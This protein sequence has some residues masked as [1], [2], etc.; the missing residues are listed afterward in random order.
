MINRKHLS[1]VMIILLISGSVMAL[2]YGMDFNITLESKSIGQK[3]RISFSDM[4]TRAG[5]GWFNMTVDNLGDQGEYC[6]LDVDSQNR[7][8]IAYYDHTNTN[9]KYTYFDGEQWVR[10]VVEN[11]AGL[12]CSIDLDMMDRPH[13][14]YYDPTGATTGN[15]K[16]AYHDGVQ[17]VTEVADPGWDV[18]EY[19]SIKI[20]E[21]GKPHIS[22]HDGDNLTL[23]YVYY[24]GAAWV[25]TTID[26]DAAVGFDT[27]LELN[28]SGYPAIAYFDNDNGD[29][30]YAY[31]D[32]A[33]WHKEAV[34]SDDEVGWGASLELNSTE[35]P[36]ISYFDETNG[37]IKYAFYNMTQWEMETVKI[38]GEAGRTTSLSLD[39]LDMPHITYQNG[40]SGD[41]EY[42]FNA[43]GGEWQFTIVDSGESEGKYNSL[44]LGSDHLPQI[45]YYKQ[46]GLN[47]LMYAAVDNTQP[48]INNDQSDDT[49]T[50]GD[51]FWFRLNAS[52]NFLLD[53]LMVNWTHGEN[54]GNETL[55]FFND[56]W[57]R[58][59]SAKH[60]LSPL[61]Y[62]FYITDL[63]G[64]L[65][66]SNQVSIPVT[67][68]DE[69]TVGQDYTP[70]IFFA[71]DN[72]TFKI[73]CRDNIQLN[74]VYVRYV[75]GG[76]Q[77]NESMAIDS[78][79]WTHSY[80]V[81]NILGDI[82]YSFYIS[83][84]SGNH[85]TTSIDHVVQSD[86]DA[87]I[88]VEEA[89]V[90]EPQT[91]QEFQLIVKIT[92]DSNI[93]SVKANYTFF[94]NNHTSADMVFLADDLWGVL[95]DVP[96][97]TTQ[98]L[99]HI[100]AQDALG[101]ILDTSIS[102]GNFQI[103]VLDI[104]RPSAI[105]INSTGPVEKVLNFT[106]TQAIWLD[107]SGSTDNLGITN[108]TWSFYYDGG[109]VKIYGPI[110]NFTFN[111]PGIYGLTLNVTDAED[112]LDGF[113]INLNITSPVAEMPTA[114]AGAD[115]TLNQGDTSFMDASGA[116][117]DEDFSYK[118]T[119]MYNDLEMS[120]IGTE[121]NFT[122]DIP[123]IYLVTLNISDGT[124]RFITDNLTITVLD[125]A[126]PEANA[127]TN[128]TVE[129]YKN[130]TFDGFFSSD[131]VGIV[132]YTWS[133]NYGN[134][135]ITLF[136]VTAKYIFSTPGNYT[137]TLIV[138]DGA[139]LTSQDDV[140]VTVI[141]AQIGEDDDD[142][143]PGD[144]GKDDEGGLSTGL[145]IVII[146]VVVLVIVVIVFILMKKKGGDKGEESLK[147]S[148]ELIGESRGTS[149]GKNPPEEDEQTT[150]I[151]D[152]I[153][154]QEEEQYPAH[155]DSQLYDGDVQ[156]SD[157][158]RNKSGT[159][160]LDQE[161]PSD[162]TAPL[163]SI[164]QGPAAPEAPPGMAEEQ[165][166][167]EPPIPMSDPAMM[168]PGE[169]PPDSPPAEVPMSPEPMAPGAPEIPVPLDEDDLPPPPM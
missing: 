96:I 53:T 143:T 163:E 46:S 124:G 21:T 150:G 103:D 100:W 12:Y 129:Q 51:L 148:D 154:G 137:V 28:D 1:F 160:P 105:V 159:A 145:L 25:N 93:T 24:N 76:D 167:G 18:G 27:S 5:D 36:R 108:Y 152:E 42:A 149:D 110:F 142:D 45:A 156:N 127:G 86:M 16:Y 118:W 33:A 39:I 166:M 115:I 139:G 157:I 44:A 7:P 63:A 135:T 122:F 101:N 161:I 117:I 19:T 89:S 74:N 97:N 133:F 69:P 13:I 56:L 68:N 15:L 61:N 168:P 120:L 38:L 85:I 104:V 58:G 99:Y 165:P 83:D 144:T 79:N 126:A 14:S 2:I 22:Y 116:A 11:G 132:N 102:N 34:D 123:G 55:Q 26:S 66:T 134:T 92:D 52:D 107:A 29:L 73:N 37:E 77:Y 128:F 41:L 80:N 138:K 151:E 47:D 87:P 70:K 54:G 147:E 119:F 125:T 81:G 88:F 146:I 30:K 67:D 78:G 162:M 10:N 164:P 71:G 62:T 72:V 140:L 82:S 91:G 59:I 75:H 113:F 57:S 43:G 8:H 130:A 64:H 40:T 98:L 95:I 35:H 155:E 6:S 121:V 169:I 20:N 60:S 50:T 131:N 3:G 49:A 48:V 32:G 141:E 153:S 112:N 31:W 4:R 106:V 109:M 158:E 94:G 65:V 114:E 9:L 84:T 136:G 17:W 111:I 90:N 23:K